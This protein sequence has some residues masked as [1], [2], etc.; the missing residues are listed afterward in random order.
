[1]TG[2]VI[3]VLK[4]ERSGAIVIADGAGVKNHLQVEICVVYFSI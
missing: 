1:M 4:P 2:G 3:S